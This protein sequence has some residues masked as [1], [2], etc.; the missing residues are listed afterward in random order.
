[1]IERTISV[2]ADAGNHTVDHALRKVRRTANFLRWLN[3]PDP[4]Y[5]HMD[6]AYFHGQIDV[7]AW[8][9]RA[10]FD[11]VMAADHEARFLLGEYVL[12]PRG[13]GL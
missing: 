7:A 9:L 5:M 12:N 8:N 3:M 6:L 2:P 1:M 13:R 10:D 4:D 11:R